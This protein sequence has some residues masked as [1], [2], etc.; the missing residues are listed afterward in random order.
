ME[1]ISLLNTFTK[2]TKT[3][4]AP[5]RYIRS[6]KTLCVNIFSGY[7]NY[8]GE[9]HVKTQNGKWDGIKK[10]DRSLTNLAV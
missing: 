8:R 5:L 6:L 7:S 2:N 9:A 1:Y 3:N 10:M 4:F